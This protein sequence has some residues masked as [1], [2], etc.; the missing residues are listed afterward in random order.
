MKK[1]KQL[2]KGFTPFCI[3]VFEAFSGTG[4]QNMALQLLAMVYPFFKFEVVGIAEIDTKVANV[5][6]HLFGKDIPNFGDISG[7]NWSEV[8]DFDLFTYS[9]PC[10]DISL[11]GKQTGF[12]KDSGT[13]SAL[14]W[15]CQDAI[16]IKKPTFLLMENVK[17]IL[18]PKFSEEFNAWLEFL[19]QQGYQ[20]FYQV[21]DAQNF[22][23]PQH[24]ERFFMVSV[25]NGQDYTFPIGKHHAYNLSSLL[26][27]NVPAKYY[28]AA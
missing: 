14:L 4:A 15:E 20:S 18:S 28:I 26:E 25:L 19:I 23:V 12:K 10:Q 9:F 8:P 7:I 2:Q 13:R 21:L 16:T 11:N 3:K 1:L 17:N 22:G 24:R 5:Y 27:E 6:H